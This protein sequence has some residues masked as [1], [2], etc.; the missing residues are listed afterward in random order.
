MSFEWYTAKAEQHLYQMREYYAALAW[1]DYL[2]R[3]RGLLAITFVRAEFDVAGR[4]WMI[5]CDYLTPDDPRIAQR[6]GW[7]VELAPKLIRIYNPEKEFVAMLVCMDT[8]TVLRCGNFE[9][10]PPEAYR[11]QR[12]HLPDWLAELTPVTPAHNG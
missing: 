5:P 3:G 2:N 1:Q 11:R 9:P 8:I 6:G 4:A 10:P 7:P 12:A